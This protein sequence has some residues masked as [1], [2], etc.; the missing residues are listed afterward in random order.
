MVKSMHRELDSLM[1]SPVS[2]SFAC[3]GERKASSPRPQRI[4]D[5]QRH[6][7]SRSLRKGR[8][9]ARMVRAWIV[10]GRFNAAMLR[11]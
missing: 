6:T 9:H 8:Q 7:T 5:D 3:Y 11:V 1:L 10:R 4:E 2:I